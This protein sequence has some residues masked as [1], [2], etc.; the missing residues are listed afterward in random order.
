MIY[1][2][3][4]FVKGWDFCKDAAVFCWVCL[5]KCGKQYLLCDSTNL[6]QCLI[7]CLHELSMDQFNV[8]F[9]SVLQTTHFLYTCLKYVWPHSILFANIYR[10]LLYKYMYWFRI[11]VCCAS[12]H[13]IWNCRKVITILNFSAYMAHIMVHVSCVS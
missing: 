5:S 8:H 4:H 10:F 12:S 3:Q 9:S 6:K 7:K 11:W 13:S 2:Y 1:V